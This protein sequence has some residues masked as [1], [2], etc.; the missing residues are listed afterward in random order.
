MI[1]IGKTDARQG[2][3]ARFYQFQERRH[4]ALWFTGVPPPEDHD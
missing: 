3:A 4:D 2:S 1:H